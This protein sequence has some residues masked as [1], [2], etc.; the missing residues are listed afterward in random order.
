M[1]L[2]YL[3]RND[4]S[5]E[6]VRGVLTVERATFYTLERPWL[7]NS[8]NISCILPGRYH[9]SFLRSSSSGRY[10]NV[11]W[12]RNVQGRAGILIHSGNLVSHTKGCLLI[13]KRAGKIAGKRAVLNSRS[14]MFEFSEL[15]EN[16]DFILYI[17]GKLPC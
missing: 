9:C 4:M 12:V 13:G 10:K 7:D 5:T 3:Y 14:A 11:Y 17:G 16:K 1:Q 6:C 2:V 15:M 8:P